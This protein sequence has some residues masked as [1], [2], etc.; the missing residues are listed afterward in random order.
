M[1]RA[2]I[3][4]IILIYSLKQFTFIMKATAAGGAVNKCIAV[5]DDD[6]LV[7]SVL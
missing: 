7:V 3:F 1:S 2:T 5:D 4:I 6:D